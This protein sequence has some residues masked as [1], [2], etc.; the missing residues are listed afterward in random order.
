MAVPAKNLIWGEREE[1]VTYWYTDFPRCRPVIRSISH[2]TGPGCLFQ[3]VEGRA[4][5]IK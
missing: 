2:Y 4:G 1:G 5:G 3:R